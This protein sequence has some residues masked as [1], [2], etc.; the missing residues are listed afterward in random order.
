MP[1]GGHAPL[2]YAPRVRSPSRL[3]PA[4]PHPPGG[5]RAPDD[6][7][8]HAGHALAS[9]ERLTAVLGEARGVERRLALRDRALV[10][11]GLFGLGF[12]GLRGIASMVRPAPEDERFALAAAFG[13]ALLA[14]TAAA[15][16]GLLLLRRRSR[17]AADARALEVLV[18]LVVRGG[19]RALAALVHPYR[20]GAERVA[21]FEDAAPAAEASE[22][23]LDAHLAPARE[24]GARADAA[25]T[26]RGDHRL[27][28]LALGVGMLAAVALLVAEMTSLPELPRQH[29]TFVD[30]ATTVFTEFQALA[31]GAGDWSLEDHGHATGAR[32]VV[33]G[34]GASDG[35]PALFVTET[36]RARD[37]HTTTRCKADDT[38]SVRACGL[39]HRFVD[40]RNYRVVRLDAA[41]RAVVATVVVDGV[42]R[43]IGRAPAPFDAGVWT[44]LDVDVRGDVVRAAVNGRETLVVRDALPARIGA[45]GLWSPAAGVA[46]FDD[47]AAEALPAAPVAREVLPLLKRSAS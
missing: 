12:V 25:R 26:D 2:R 34:R 19:T 29:W 47:L 15:T 8:T 42:E 45:V 22:P 7:R 23:G 11:L 5:P 24:A 38:L 21:A 18:E 27:G 32:A 36:V 9:P 17:V 43:E 14:S 30:D 16:T 46:W 20:S 39:V 3:S 10:S 28:T 1:S 40:A 31:D 33:N 35:P 41:A 4:D 37:V 6:D 13:A 44:A